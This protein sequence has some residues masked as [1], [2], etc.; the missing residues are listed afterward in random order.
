MRSH[1]SVSSGGKANPCSRAIAPGPLGLSF[2]FK[3]DKVVFEGLTGLDE[4]SAGRDLKA[5]DGR[6][7]AWLDSRLGAFERGG[8]CLE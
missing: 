7:A 3:K 2:A 6:L 1:E 8:D 4:G 5:F